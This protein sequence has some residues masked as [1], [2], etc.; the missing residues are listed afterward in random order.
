MDDMDGRDEDDVDGDHKVV[1]DVYSMG[2]QWD[3]LLVG[4]NRDIYRY[5]PM[6]VV[7]EHF[8]SLTL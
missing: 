3:K 8:L 4:D 6:N 2:L 1:L 5:V 7:D